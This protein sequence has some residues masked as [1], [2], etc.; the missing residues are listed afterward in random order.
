MLTFIV[1][2]GLRALIKRYFRARVALWRPATFKPYLK[3]IKSFFTRLGEQYPDLDSFAGLTR[4][5]IEP[6]LHPP[7]WI[8]QKGQQHSITPYRWAKM[9]GVLDGMF[10][11]MRPHDWPEAPPRQL[12]SYED[13]LGR[14]VRRAQVQYLR[15]SCSNWVLTSIDSPVVHRLRLCSAVTP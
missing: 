14:P 13:K 11:Y 9:A 6:A 12:I 10:T 4:A 5:M 15:M 1:N 7:Y 3:H 8:D 2:P